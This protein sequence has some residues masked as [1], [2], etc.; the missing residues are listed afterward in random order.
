VSVV[1]AHLICL[2]LVAIDMLA[3]VWRIQW[4]M[5]GLKLDLTLKDAFVLNIFGDAANSLTPLRIGG[6]PARL[7]GM[8]RTRIPI[9]AAVLGITLEAIVSRL[10]LA[11]AVVWLG[12]QFAP[13]WW[14][15]VGPQLWASANAAWPWIV[16]LLLAGALF[17]WYTQ[18]VVSP[19]TRRMRRSMTR[20]RVYWRRMPR[21]PLLVGM[22]LSLVS[23]AAR[24]A[25]LPVLALSLVDPPPISLLIFGSFTLLYSQM[26][27]P[28][29]AGAG[30]VELG[31]MAGAAG[32]LGGNGSL[33]LAWRFYST[34][35]GVLLGVYLAAKIYGWPALRRLAHQSAG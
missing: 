13:A 33:L 3:R 5:A 7:A 30:V 26:V 18:R 9:T 2:L 12:W 11:A 10:M 23:I 21:W 22:L 20:I 29:P 27:L 14:V 17:W 31:F 34:G 35:L 8:L 4:I 15:S 6:E 28:T 24:V 25:L 16:L 19:M 32:E 1:E